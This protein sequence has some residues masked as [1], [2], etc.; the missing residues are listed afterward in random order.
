MAY[1]PNATLP[2]SQEG[3]LQGILLTLQQMVSNTGFPD[4]LTRRTRVLLEAVT[5]ANISTNVAQL[6]GT[7]PVTGLGASAAG[8]LRVTPSNDTFAGLPSTAPQ[9]GLITIY[10][11]I[12]TQ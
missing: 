7:A 3:I 2:D 11:N 4:P 10:Q 9:I 12:I 5:A 1:S 8:V 6:N